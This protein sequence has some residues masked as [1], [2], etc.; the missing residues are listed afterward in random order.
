MVNIICHEEMAMF[1]WNLWIGI[2]TEHMFYKWYFL[3]WYNTPVST[4]LHNVPKYH[5][6][7][8]YMPLAINRLNLVNYPQFDRIITF[9][10]CN[11]LPSTINIASKMK[12][13]NKCSNNTW[14]LYTYYIRQNYQRGKTLSVREENGYSR[15]NLLGSMFYCQTTK[16]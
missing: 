7:I 6:S 15:E 14:K 11:S 9:Y 10:S 2:K 4:C 13:Y 12:D 8:L 1:V 16:P 3:S 5:S